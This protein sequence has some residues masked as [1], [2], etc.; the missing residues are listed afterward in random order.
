MTVVLA[1]AGGGFENT[2]S[3]EEIAAFDYVVAATVHDV[4]DAGVGHILKVDRYLKGSGGE[5]LVRM[6]YGPGLQAATH[7]RR[8]DTGCHYDGRREPPLRINDFAYLGLW[9]NSNGTVS[10]GLKYRPKDGVVTF[11][12]KGEGVRTLQVHEL[13]QLLLQFSEQTEATEPQ[14]NPY[15]LMRFLKITTE[16][17]ERYRLNPDRSVSWIDPEKYP[18][19]TSN[20]GSHVVF[21]L[22]DGMLGF[23]YLATRKKQIAPWLREEQTEVLESAR[24]NLARGFARYGWMHVVPGLYAQFSPNSDFA[25]VQDETRL[26]VYLLYSV[27]GGEISVGYGHR[28]AVREIASFDATWRSAEDQQPLAWN[29]NSTAIA[30]QDSQGIWLWKFLENAEPQLVVQSQEGQELLDFSATGRYLRYGWPADWT[31]LEVETG[32]TWKDSLITPDESRLVHFVSDR[33][34][35]YEKRQQLE[36]CG[37]PLISC[38]LVIVQSPHTGVG[39]EEPPQDVF[40]HERDL[41]GLLYR[42]GFQSIR[43]SYALENAFCDLR[44]CWGVKTPAINAFAYDSRYRQQ[45]FA[46]EDTRIGFGLR[47]KEDYYDSIDLSEHLDSPIVDLEWGQPIFYEGR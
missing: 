26:V 44:I 3:K 42:Y 5:F 25:A 22:D 43:W 19:A 32:E 47:K 21:R 37:L 27:I 28:M 14:S 10:V 9:S 6:P 36:E 34:E 35:D 12:Q 13:E 39:S 8:Y 46:F 7:V 17:G 38:P 20:D 31:L 45:A 16:S 40:W 15:P 23:Q 11:Y 41:L 4:D 24:S 2:L 33:P 29:A 30:Y 18:Y 1:C